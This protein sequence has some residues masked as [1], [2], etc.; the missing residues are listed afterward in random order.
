MFRMFN[1]L[2]MYSTVLY[3]FSFF[4]TPEKTLGVKQYPA[5]RSFQRSSRQR[6]H[7]RRGT[8]HHAR[9]GNRHRSARDREQ[10]VGHGERPPI[11]RLPPPRTAAISILANSNQVVTLIEGRGDDDRVGS[12]AEG[13][14][15][16]D[17]S[18]EFEG[19]PDEGDDADDE[20]DDCGGGTQLFDL[21]IVTY[22]RE[23]HRWRGGIRG[24]R[25]E[26]VRVN[27]IECFQRIQRSSPTAS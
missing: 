6:L 11:Q 13:R 8:H 17:A 15:H 21:Q 4:A 27:I 7:G 10:Y 3:F 16:G 20:D 12:C 2:Y 24:R 23:F 1:M 14:T 25:E 9:H 26:H 18:P 5:D 19:G 22:F